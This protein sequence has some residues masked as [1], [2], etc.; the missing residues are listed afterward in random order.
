MFYVKKCFLLKVTMCRTAS[1]V[2]LITENEIWICKPTGRNQGKGIFLVRSLAD[3]EH[4]L[5][6]TSS[7]KNQ[8]MRT[9]PRPL[10]RIIQR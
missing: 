3:L 9:S 1:C 10:N 6:E 7:L 8:Q 2:A 4:A 5:A